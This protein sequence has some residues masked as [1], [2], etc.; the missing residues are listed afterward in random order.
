[1]LSLRA[2]APPPSSH[3]I[4]PS[5]FCRL[6]HSSAPCCSQQIDFSQEK[7]LPPQLEHVQTRVIETAPYFFRQRLDYTFY[8]RDVLL[9]NQITGKQLQGLDELMAYFGRLAVL[10][11]ICLPH[12]QMDVVGCYAE[13]D[14]GTVR[15]RWRVEYVSFPRLIMNPRLLRFDYRVKNLSWYDGYSIFTVDGNGKV[16]KVSVFFCFYSIFFVF[17]FL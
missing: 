8:R 15:L 5:L 2:A 7:P 1:M 13:L 3:P 4:W 14:D 16:S 10:G 6:L 17:N 11:K 9:D 12:V